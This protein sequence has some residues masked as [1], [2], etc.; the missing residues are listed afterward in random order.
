MFIQPNRSIAARF[1]GEAGSLDR[2]AAASSG[3]TDGLVA[4]GWALLGIS[5][6][7]W[8]SAQFAH[9]FYRMEWINIWFQ[10]DQPRVLGNMLDMR[11]SHRSS[12]HPIFSILTVPLTNLLLLL[13]MT[14]VG[15]ARAL[16]A[17]AGGLSAALF[18]L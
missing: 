12:V 8:A 17:G 13:G 9:T 14:P 15:A 11:G 5:L 18:Y 6:S 7:W 16:V 3:V 10:A 1:P 4:A 2:E